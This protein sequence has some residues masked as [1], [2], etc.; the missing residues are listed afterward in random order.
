MKWRI[1]FDDGSAIER[2]ANSE[3]DAVD[4]GCDYLDDMQ[5]L[6]DQAAGLSFGNIVCVERVE[7]VSGPKP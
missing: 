2:E 7:L 1:S 3:R 5:P 4:Q 6:D